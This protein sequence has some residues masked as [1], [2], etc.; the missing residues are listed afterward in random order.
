MGPRLKE[1]LVFGDFEG[2]FR[3]KSRIKMVITLGRLVLFIFKYFNY[4]REM[5]RHAAI[6]HVYLSTQKLPSKYFGLTVAQKSTD[7]RFEVFAITS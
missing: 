7:K 5:H 2:Y 4:F 3:I 6:K 1:G